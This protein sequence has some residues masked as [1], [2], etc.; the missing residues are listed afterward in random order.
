MTTVLFLALGLSMDAFAVTISNVM[1]YSNL[2]M[3]N[4]IAMP[5]T[6]GLFQ[7]GMP[8]IGFL[9]GALFATAVE[10]VAHWI[11]LIILGFLGIKAI[12]ENLKEQKEA[13]STRL[14]DVKTLLTQAVA[15][16]I[17]ALAVGITLAV[18]VPLK[19]WVSAS[20]IAV[21]TALTCFVGL[22]IGK[23]AGKFLKDYAGIF[24]GAVLIAI[25]IKIF[26]EHFLG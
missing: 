9:L 23:I 21:V 10:S 15:T 13:C 25:G 1:C 26:V 19:I 4:K 5:L 2:T 16:S 22:F 6:F 7:G 17:D 12:V 18:A 24:G 14:F 8:L 20:I 11:A 3:K